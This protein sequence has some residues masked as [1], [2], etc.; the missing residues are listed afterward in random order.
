MTPIER[1]WLMGW[2]A[3]DAGKPCEPPHEPGD[4]AQAWL[5]GWHSRGGPGR[6]KRWVEVEHNRLGLTRPVLV[7]LRQGI[8]GRAARKRDS[9]PGME[10]LRRKLDRME[11]ERDEARMEL[12]AAENRIRDLEQQLVS[13]ADVARQRPRAA[14]IAG[15]L[16]A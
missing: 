9:A 16:A 12:L 5:C 1:A 15:R 3:K 2:A 11:R 13:L 6:R 10:A 4:V 14:E 8:L 7:R